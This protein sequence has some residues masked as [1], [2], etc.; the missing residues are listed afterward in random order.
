MQTFAE[1]SAKRS[2]TMFILLEPN[3]FIRRCERTSTFA[4]TRSL[5]RYRPIFSYNYSI[6]FC[7]DSLLILLLLF[8]SL[9]HRFDC[10]QSA[11]YQHDDDSK[12]AVYLIQYSQI[13]LDARESE[14]GREGER[15][16]LKQT[17]FQ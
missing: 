10:G 1:E 2:I 3:V 11:P 7:F 16:R 12:H 14:R 5:A 6:G 13:E 17:K 15:K 8:F 4:R 9:F